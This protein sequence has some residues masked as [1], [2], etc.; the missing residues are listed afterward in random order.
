MGGSIIGLLKRPFPYP[1]A[2]PTFTSI[3]RN[4][5]RSDRICYSI[6]KRAIAIS[7]EYTNSAINPDII[8]DGIHGNEFSPVE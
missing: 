3:N 4:W 2:I 6:I 7:D 8:S 5:S 1:K